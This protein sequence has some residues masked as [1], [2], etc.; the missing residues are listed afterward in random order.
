MLVSEF[1][2]YL[3]HGELSQLDLGADIGNNLQLPKLVASINLGLTELYKRFPINLKEV[4]IQLNNW[5]TNYTI[6]SAHAESQMPPEGNPDNYYVKDSE[7]YPF[8]DDIL[9]IEQVFNEDG[10]ELPLNDENLKYS[11]F[12]VGHNVIS[13]PYPEDENAI[14]V[15]YRAHSAKIAV[16]STEIDIPQQFVEPLVNYVAHRVFAG[17]NMSSAEAINYYARFEASCALINNLGL[18]AKPSNTNMRLENS[19][20]V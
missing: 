2:S 8:T 5:Q 20:W 7:Y 1:K 18:Y 16:D 13:H 10:E 6:S 12:T 14:T 15:I 4:I 19:G 11:L 17:I 9:S 3:V